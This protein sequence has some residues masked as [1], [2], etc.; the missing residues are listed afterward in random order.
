MPCSRWWSSPSSVSWCTAGASSAA[1]PAPAALAPAGL[2][3]ATLAPAGL[4]PATLAPAGLL[5]A[6][7]APA[8][9]APAPAALAPADAHR[10]EAATQSRGHASRTPGWES[11]R[12][13]GRIAQT[14]RPDSSDPEAG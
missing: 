7:L 10:P 11:L 5:P 12:P 13:R 4:L 3:P 6:A 14:P 2:L 1:K 8:N 9:L